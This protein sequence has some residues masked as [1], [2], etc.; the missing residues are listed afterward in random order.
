VLPNACPHVKHSRAW[1]A[2]AA[3]QVAQK[4]DEDTI[5]YRFF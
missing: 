5:A 2:F 1:V 3:P 4:R